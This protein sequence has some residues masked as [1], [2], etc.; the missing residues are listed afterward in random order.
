MFLQAIVHCLWI[1]ATLLLT[2]PPIPRWMLLNMTM[3]WLIALML[4]LPASLRCCAGS[5]GRI[6]FISVLTTSLAA[7]RD[8]MRM[9]CRYRG[10]SAI[11]YPHNAFT[12]LVR[13]L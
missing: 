7:N 12:V 13:L 8:V 3:P 2:V 9:V 4:K 5:E 1:V 11:R 10:V 6:L